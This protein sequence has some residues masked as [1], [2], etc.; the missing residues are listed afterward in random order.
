MS[1][2]PGRFERVRADHLHAQNL[3]LRAYLLSS[4][5]SSSLLGLAQ[6]SVLARVLPAEQFALV[7]AATAAATYMALLGEPAVLGYERLG[8]HAR[9]HDSTTGESRSV[10]HTVTM[11]LMVVAPTIAVLIG[12]VMG[13]PLCSLVVALWAVSL[14]QLRW[15]SVQYLNWQEQSHFATAMLVNSAARASGMLIAGVTTGDGVLVLLVGAV[16]SLIATVFVSPRR[17]GLSL[18]RPALR[19]L[20][21]VGA[22]LTIASAAVSSMGSWP[23]LAGNALLPSETFAN[24]VAQ[25]SLAGS[26]FGVTVGFVLVF[27]WPQAK[28]AWDEGDS[29]GALDVIARYTRYTL[30]LGG[31][32]VVLFWIF[33]DLITRILLGPNYVG[34]LIPS[35]VTSL[36]CVSAIAG[37]NS[38]YLRLNYRQNWWAGIAVTAALFQIPLV[39]FATQ[40]AQLLGLMLAMALTSWGQCMA[41]GLVARQP[42]M[43]VNLVVSSGMGILAAALAVAVAQE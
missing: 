22:P 11:L 25:A 18:N 26:F 5:V 16:A 14:V 34:H 15:V 41:A 35:Y 42:R 36:A 27:G 24:Y 7:A 40:Q 38:W 12:L 10:A 23:T 8:K 30:V 39:W 43:M 9:E 29:E 32:A 6:L 2:W 28:K 4:R 1:R 13:K 17:A 20:L 21:K 33:G 37:L 3:R 31:A 19:L